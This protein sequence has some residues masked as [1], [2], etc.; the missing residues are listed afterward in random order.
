LVLVL[1]VSTPAGPAHA[2]SVPATSAETVV[3]EPDNLVRFLDFVEERVER[4]TA[5]PDGF[6][7]RLGGI[8]SGSDIAA[9]PMWQR[10]ALGGA[11]RLRTSSAISIVGDYDVEAGLA[12]PELG[13]HRLSLTVGASERHLAREHFYGLG[14]STTDT[15]HVMFEFD[16]REAHL[17]M[18]VAAASWLDFTIGGGWADYSVADGTYTRAPSIS[19]RFD[20][21]SAP[22]LGSPATFGVL[23]ASAVVDWRDVPGNPRNGGRYRLTI[24]RHSDRSNTQYSFARAALDLEQHFSW[25]RRQRVLSLRGL[26][27]VSTPDVGHDVPFYLQPTLGGSRMLRGFV[28]DRFR[29][30]NL[31]WA[32]AEY[33]WDLWPFLGAVLFYEGGMVADEP[34]ALTVKSLERDYGFGFRAGSARTIAVRT[35]VAF[36]SG[37]GTRIAMRFSHAF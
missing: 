5:Q 11:M 30:R 13:S 23:A 18:S 10:R 21:Q 17:E 3:R 7:V 20:R 27:V 35:D 22:G 16:R 24:D 19:T 34:S 32:Q 14:A 29:A 25:W 6:G 8:A 1:A 28:T 12:I 4:F 26:A 37:E 15:N 2:Q 36:G 33:G 9:G 31:V